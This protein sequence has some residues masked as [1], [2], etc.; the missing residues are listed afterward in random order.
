MDFA[1]KT[2]TAG[3][4]PR[5]TEYTTALLQDKDKLT[6]FRSQIANRG[7]HDE[8]LIQEQLRQIEEQGNERKPLRQTILSNIRL[9]LLVRRTDGEST[10]DLREG[11]NGESWS[12]K[13]AGRRKES[14]T[15]S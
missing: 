14:L 4:G 12:G 3:G 1:T 8:P 2:I 13:S 5:S 15:A 11:A 10:P 6:A 9:I 7:R